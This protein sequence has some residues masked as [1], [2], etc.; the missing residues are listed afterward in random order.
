MRRTLRIAKREYLATVRT[1]GFLVG[2]VVA[3]LLM[4]GSLI[5]IALLKGHVDTTDKRIAVVDRSGLVTSAL[6]AAAEE[7]NAREVRDAK[8]GRRVKPAYV[9][10]AV[11]P[12]AYPDAQRLELSERVRAKRLHAFVEIGPGILHPRADPAAARVEYHAESASLDDVRGWVENALNDRLRALRREAAGLTG[13]EHADLFDWVG[14]EPMGLVQADERTGEV[15]KAERSSPIQALAVPLAMILLMWIVLMMGAVP[16]LNA[17]MEEKSQRIA[18][19]LLAA[20]RPFE[21]MAGKLLGGVAVSLTGAA[22]YISVGSASLLYLGFTEQFPFRILPW[23]V[24][25][26]LAAVL[27]LGSICAALGSACNDAKDAQNL[28]LPAIF[29]VLIP[30]F[31]LVPAVT[32]PNSPVITGFSLFPLFTPMLML[33]RQASPTGIPAWQPWVGL[34]G[35]TLFTVLSVWAGGRVFRV[36]IMIQGKKPR[37]G[38]LVRLALRG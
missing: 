24:A 9:V 19:V 33:A 16:Q 14:A 20:V 29:P 32:Q 11:E 26:T 38:E 8:T 10:E 12:G 36:E 31:M 35:V 7:R 6:A 23:F 5:A 22:F 28:A 13:P 15:R 1:K 18:E 27:M 21:L 3:P 2:L 34:A 4:G 25:Y 17:V 37:L 30:M